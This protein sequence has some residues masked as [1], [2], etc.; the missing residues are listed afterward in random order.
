MIGRR[1]C[2]SSK[3][4]LMEST[5]ATKKKLVF[6]IEHL[7]NPSLMELQNFIQYLKFK[8]SSTAIPANDQ[9]L[10]PAEQDPIL[11]AIGMVSITPFADVIDGTLYGAI[12]L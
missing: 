3:E 1:L 9:V 7:S 6:E 2:G 4:I 8:Q 5:Q 12:S 10:L 11:Q